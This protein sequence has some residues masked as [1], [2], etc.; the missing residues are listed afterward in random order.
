MPAEF[1]LDPAMRAQLRTRRWVAV[2][3]LAERQFGVIALWQLRA[4][5]ISPSAVG[6]A[7]ECRRLL[8]IHRGVFAVGHRVL[9]PRGRW[10]AAVLAGGT[11]AVLSHRSAAV[12]WEVLNGSGGP[13]EITSPRRRHRLPAVRFHHCLLGADE[14]TSIDGIP[15]TTV[16]RTLFDL[17]AVVPPHRLRRAINEAEYRR[18]GN[19]R[20]LR[21]LVDRYPGRRGVR[22]L[23][24]IL[25]E[26]GIG[27][28]RTR[29]ELEDRF[30][31][32]LR[33]RDLPPAEPNATLVLADRT[34]E[35]DQLW[36][37]ARLVV[38]L[39]G[40]AAHASE[41][42]FERDRERDRALVVAGWTVVRVTWRQLHDHPERLA[43]ELRSLLGSSAG[44]PRHGSRSEAA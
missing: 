27:R 42:G 18:R 10:M 26:R 35:V 12:A 15:A 2:A 32:F 20:T 3:A 9:T 41:S 4:A 21:S 16:A 11:G 39:D 17:A 19:A 29:S 25:A 40:R 22:A 34:L 33:N 8:A 31:Q 13:I 5:G 44:R 24:A 28:T 23:R 6:R 43:T 30:T 37:T 38:E 36:R 1:A 7:V 14:V